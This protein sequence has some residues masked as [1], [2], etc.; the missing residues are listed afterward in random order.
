MNKYIAFKATLALFLL[1]SLN[2]SSAAQEN[3]TGLVERVRPAVV[4]LIAYN[5]SGEVIECGTGFFISSEGRLL[6]NRHLLRNASSAEV[7]TREGGVYPIEMV[8]AEDLNLDLI[9]LLVELKGGEVPYLKMTDVIANK[10]EQV[11]AVGHQHIVQG[12]VSYVRTHSGPGRN[13][14]FSTATAAQATGSPVINKK[15]EVIGI[16]ADQAVG[17]QMVNLAISSS[18]ALALVPSRTDTLAD[19]NAR[20]KANR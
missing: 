13:F 1:N 17:G 4:A 7:H 5:D 6:S 12:F 3:F 10:D 9:E 15:G 16:A 2:W 18:S 11:A 14:L 19:W 20:I 8:I